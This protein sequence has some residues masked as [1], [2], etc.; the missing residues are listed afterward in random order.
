MGQVGESERTTASSLN[1]LTAFSAHAIAAGSAGAAIARWDYATV[2]TAA[3]AIAILAGFLFRGLL[4]RFENPQG[5]EARKAVPD[6]Y[7]K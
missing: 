2:L 4:I 1:Y 5:M 6:R 7:P 3:A